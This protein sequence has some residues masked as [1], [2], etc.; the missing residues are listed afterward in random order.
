MG[1]DTHKIGQ[2][3]E[4]HASRLLEARGWRVIE[5]NVRFR[6]RE[7]DLIVQRGDVLAFVEVKGRHGTGFGR[8]EEAVT[9][10]K[11]RE[12]ESVARWWIARH[13]EAELDF[14]FDVVA[15]SQDRDGR[16]RTRH[17]EDAWRP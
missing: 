9:A 1:L 10:R 2:S 4:D 7:V 5:R 8:P 12:I 13:G 14:R 17:I 11:R 15:V 6:R 3:F 16:L